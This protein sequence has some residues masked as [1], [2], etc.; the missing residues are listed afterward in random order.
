M[1]ES[2]DKVNK[3][4]IILMKLLDY[5][6]GDARTRFLDMPIVNIGTTVNLLEALKD[7]LSKKGLNFGKCISFM[8]DATT[9]LRALGQGFK[10]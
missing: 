5:T 6:V 10:S 8:S 7:S 2:N 4:C 1:D 9:S 3:S